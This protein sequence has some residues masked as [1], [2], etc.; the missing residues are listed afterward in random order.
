M[1]HIKY[2]SLSIAAWAE[3]ASQR[4]SCGDYSID[5]L[6]DLSWPRCIQPV[7]GAGC[8]YAGTHFAF[9]AADKLRVRVSAVSGQIHDVK[10]NLIN[11]Y[12]FEYM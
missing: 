8:V 5:H 10:C 9:R 3:D 11:D 2:L 1:L 4:T 6:F 7:V 12:N